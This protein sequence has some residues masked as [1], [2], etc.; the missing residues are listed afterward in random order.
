MW[1]CVRALRLT[2]MRMVGG[3]A[4]TLQTAVAVNPCSP[5]SFSVL[6]TVTVPASARITRLNVSQSTGAGRAGEFE[7]LMS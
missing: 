4:Q 5:P 1:A 3:S 2:T 6:M 7:D